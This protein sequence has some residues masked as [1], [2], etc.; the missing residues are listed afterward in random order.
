M[1]SNTLRALHSILTSSE[2]ANELKEWYAKTYDDDLYDKFCEDV[3]PLKN[4]KIEIG[5]LTNMPHFNKISDK[6]DKA[7][8]LKWIAKRLGTKVNDEGYLSEFDVAKTA[9]L[10]QLEN[11]AIDNKTTLEKLLALKVD[12]FINKLVPPKALILVKSGSR[13]RLA[14]YLKACEQVLLHPESTQLN[15]TNNVGQTLLKAERKTAYKIPHIKL[16][17]RR[18][19]FMTEAGMQV[20]SKLENHVEK[21]LSRIAV[22]RD[23]ANGM[24]EILKNVLLYWDNVIVKNVKAVETVSK[25]FDDMKDWQ[26]GSVNL[27]GKLP[28]LP[29]NKENEA[30]QN[31]FHI[32]WLNHQNAQK[33]ANTFSFVLYTHIRLLM[34]YTNNESIVQS[35]KKNPDKTTIMDA[36]YGSLYSG[37]LLSSTMRQLAFR[38][39]SLVE[40]ESSLDFGADPATTDW[41]KGSE[42]L[43]KMTFVRIC[44]LLFYD[45]SID[46]KQQIKQES[47][48]SA[49]SDYPIFWTTFQKIIQI[50]SSGKVTVSLLNVAKDNKNTAAFDHIALHLNALVDD[51]KISA[52]IA[53]TMIKN[54]TVRVLITQL[55]SLKYEKSN[56]KAELDI[57]V[58]ISNIL[59]RTFPATEAVSVAGVEPVQ[60]PAYHKSMLSEPPVYAIS[61]N[62]LSMIENNNLQPS[63][64]VK[65]VK[66]HFPIKDKVVSAPGMPY[67]IQ[68]LK[69]YKDSIG[70][71]LVG[72]F[73]AGKSKMT[74]ENGE[75]NITIPYTDIA[76]AATTFLWKA[77]MLAFPLALKAFREQCV[78]N[79]KCSAQDLSTIL[80]GSVESETD[81]TSSPAE[82]VTL[83]TNYKAAVSLS[84]NETYF[85]YKTPVTIHVVII[86]NAMK[87]GDYNFM[88]EYGKVHLS[89][90]YGGYY[91]IVKGS[92]D[93][94]TISA[95]KFKFDFSVKQLDSVTYQLRVESFRAEYDHNRRY[96]TVPLVEP[97]KAREEVYLVCMVKWN[98]SEH[99]YWGDKYKAIWV[100]EGE[101]YNC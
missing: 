45:K 64:I 16:A 82:I 35:S 13:Y 75:P 27:F 41:T 94:A 31:Y 38:I 91:S 63:R 95:G 56:D 21:F 50:S 43:D 47:S 48:S 98:V 1:S 97:S 74:D 42:V 37:P 80:Q 73:E 23:N 99:H 34:F 71:A 61:P 54:I 22:E 53:I 28:L 62:V 78:T 85:L 70:E 36:V 32:E 44:A 10:L 87:Y 8:F 4:G 93:P 68:N 18:V 19:I 5:D 66:E 49:Y 11:W 12:A 30:A 89:R 60:P 57:I 88:L 24:P 58:A 26:K 52:D 83:Y 25:V 92:T 51:G 9:I 17:T 6:K 29:K 59:L 33:D 3:F 100:K 90:H 39:V 76:S 67:N 77:Y 20:Y 40:N 81:S 2:S 86:N 101:P 46:I 79:E 14:K 72:V 84:N 65:L 55:K 7:G 69:A 15:R 96:V